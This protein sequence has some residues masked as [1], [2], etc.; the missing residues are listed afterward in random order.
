MERM[1]GSNTKYTHNYRGLIVKKIV[2]WGEL[3][4]QR[5]NISMI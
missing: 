1:N 5:R 3:V 2:I 4:A